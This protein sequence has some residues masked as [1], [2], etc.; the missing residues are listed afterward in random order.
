M[1]VL[2]K[3]LIQ[4]AEEKAISSGAFSFLELMYNAGISAAKEI[5]QKFS[6]NEKKIT[7]VCGNGNNGGDG[8]VIAQYLSEIGAQVSLLLPLGEPL[9][10]SAKFYFNKLSKIKIIDSMPSDTDVIIDAVFGVGLN[11]APAPELE[12]LFEQINVQ[13]AVKVSID[14][15]SGVCADTG[16]IFSKAIKADYTISFIAAK[17]C[18]FLPTSSEYCGIVSI[19]DIGVKTDEY[20]Y[21]T[22]EKP[23]LIQRPKNS[24]KGTFGTALLICGSYGMAGAAILAT[25]ACLRSGVGIAKCIV[26]KGIYS[27]FTSRIPEAVCLPTSQT[28][29]GTLKAAKINIP[30]LCKSSSALLFGCGVGKSRDTEKILESILKYS[31]I[32]TVIDADGINLLAGRINLLKKSKAPLILTPHPAEMARLCS[33][34]TKEIEQ[35]RIGITKK[36]VSEFGCTLILKGANTI[37]ASPDGELQFN[38]TGNS[39]MA[40]GGSGDVLSG[41][42]V[43][44]LAQGYSVKDAALSAVYIHGAAADKALSKKSAEALLPTDF[45]E[46]L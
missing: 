17:P 22:I 24:H 36:F 28:R 46:E 45:I 25:L 10:D 7:L 3:A 29:K 14:I 38:T 6:C 23:T 32:P 35:D 21:K 27:A 44:L 42:L 18:F 41:I 34:S 15:P 33:L 40:T 37:V 16:I 19:C 13:K 39:G 11:R 2:T 43:S 20:S 31:N 30:E 26:T 1:L 5:D 9:T 12:E 4:K 8:F